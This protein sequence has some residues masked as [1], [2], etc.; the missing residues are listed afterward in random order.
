MLSVDASILQKIEGLESQIKSQSVQECKEF[1]QA[2][3]NTGKIQELN[4]KLIANLENCRVSTLNF[5]EK[6]LKHSET[7][8]KI[9]KEQQKLEAL[10]SMQGII[11]EILEI[12]QLMRNLLNSRHYKEA[13][14]LLQFIERIPSSSGV[15]EEL[16][17]CAETARK[18]LMD[19]LLDT[20]SEQ[21]DIEKVKNALDCLKAL[22]SLP[23][24]KVVSVFFDCKCLS[25]RKILKKFSGPNINILTI[26]GQI[27]DFLV[28]VDFLGK[29]I[30]N[31]NCEEF[32]LFYVDVISGIIEFLGKNIPGSI[33][34]IADVCKR[35]GEINEKIFVP[36]GCNAWPEASKILLLSIREK[37]STY[38][39]KTLV[40]F[41]NLIKVYTWESSGS[42]DNPLLEFG[43]IAVLY[44]NTVHI[45]NEIR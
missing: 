11:T 13:L 1:I 27:D 22:N 34:E 2:L 6:V 4:S 18:K 10:S 24:E 35:F 20:V 9:L 39:A 5:K 38:T 30:F 42:K 17:K 40:N 31:E 37:I 16:E 29:K 28:K 36:V 19:D 26:L 44:N 23:D 45:I 32:M 43:S 14:Q 12:P 41:E 15:F 21:F 7:I 3:A 33:G 8:E 25:F